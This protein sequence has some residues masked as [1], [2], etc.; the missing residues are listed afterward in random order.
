MKMFSLIGVGER[1][2][3]GIE[4]I[5]K[6]WNDENWI[7]PELDEK[8]DPDRVE[9]LLKMENNN[10]ADNIENNTNTI[11]DAVSNIDN[12]VNNREILN[13]VFL[14]SFTDNEIKVLALAS[15][16]GSVNNAIV[17]NLLGKNSKEV[18][19][20]L[21]ALVKRNVLET[22]GVGRGVEYKL[23]GNIKNIINS[24]N[25]DF[26]NIEKNSL[27]DEQLKVIT[28]IK[29]NGFISSKIATDRI[30]ISKRKSVIIFNSLINRGIID[31]VG[32]GS[33]TRY[34]LKE[35]NKK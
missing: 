27:S 13:D 23:N 3:S 7:S 30:G 28:L 2:G 22:S 19:S 1:A 14:S 34:V 9:L 8:F 17:Q 16:N 11:V 21:K 4:K 31:R 33:N 12:K 24:K 20:I 5:Q 10:V 32:A 25:F 26:D 6:A 35:E 29:E 18:H 15:V